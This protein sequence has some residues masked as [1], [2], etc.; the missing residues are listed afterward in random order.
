VLEDDFFFMPSKKLD[1][2]MK[3]KKNTAVERDTKESFV[4]DNFLVRE[5]TE[6]ELLNSF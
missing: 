2:K 3:M 4:L 1:V 6:S 5:L